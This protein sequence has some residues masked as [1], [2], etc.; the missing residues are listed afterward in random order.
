MLIGGAK[1]QEENQ[2]SFHEYS[3]CHQTM[4]KLPP[5]LQ[6][7]LQEEIGHAVSTNIVNVDTKHKSVG[8]QSNKAIAERV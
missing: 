3:F 8:A 2:E 5:H 1:R 4:P 7:Q 6:K